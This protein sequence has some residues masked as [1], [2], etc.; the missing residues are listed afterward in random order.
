M[1]ASDVCTCGHR[2]H[3]HDGATRWCQHYESEVGG[4]DDS[5]VRCGCREFK[6]RERPTGSREIEALN[7][8]IRLRN[9]M[10]S[11]MSQGSVANE[12]AMLQV[13]EIAA[14]TDAI[15]RLGDGE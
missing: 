7:T 11:G 3:E 14:L 10:R 8:V 9:H 4:G 13:V 12:I 5:S 1:A 15:N 2:E 6:F